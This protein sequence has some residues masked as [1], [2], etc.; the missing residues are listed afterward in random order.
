M[1]PI[2]Q[3][4]CDN[5]ESAMMHNVQ[6]INQALIPEELRFQQECAYRVFQQNVQMQQK[7]IAPP[8]VNPDSSAT[9]STTFDSDAH[10]AFMRSLG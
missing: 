7:S 6:S 4:T 10:R 8:G 9:V 3:Q 1:S 2:D 5:P